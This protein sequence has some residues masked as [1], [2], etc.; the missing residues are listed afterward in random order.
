M[1]AVRNLLGMRFGR[2][3]VTERSENSVRGRARWKV[4]CNCGNVST[5]QTGDLVSGKSQSC[6]CLAK[7]RRLAAIT[8][9]GQT[10]N[11]TTTPEASAYYG[12]KRRCTNSNDESWEYYGGRGIEF[13][14]TS[15]EEF[16]AELG[17]KPEPKHLYSVDRIDNNGHYEPGNVRWATDSQQVY[18]RRKLTGSSQ[19]RGVSW[20]KATNK[21]SAYI[22][23]PKQI[24]LGLF[25]SEIAAALAHD[26]AARE[27]F[28]EFALTNF[29]LN[30]L[31]HAA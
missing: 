24:H 21:W 3:T 31:A 22:K 4:T 17:E 6:G 9:H 10:R 15:F 16:Y 2:W 26:T 11:R 14:F 25:D 29:P 1:T 20:H 12:A 28:G 5:A 13:R 19:H 18:N 27:H 23:V 30:E 7:E 8:T